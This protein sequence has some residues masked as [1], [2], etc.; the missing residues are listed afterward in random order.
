MT[1]PEINKPTGPEINKPAGDPQHKQEPPKPEP[2]PYVK[3]EIHPLAKGIFPPITGEEYKTLKEDIEAHGVR[4]AIVLYQGKILDGC[5]RD[6]VCYELNID[7]PTT[8]LPQDADPLEF[9]VSANI[10]RRHLDESQRGM[11]VAKLANMKRGDNQHTGQGQP[12]GATSRVLNVGE[13]TATRC[14]T[15]LTKGIP[16][17]TE[18]V[19]EGKLRASV[20]E[21]VANLDKGRQAEL[22]E[23]SVSKIKEAVKTPEALPQSTPQSTA[24]SNEV[25]KLKKAY[26][27]ALKKLGKAEQEAAVADMLKAFADLGL[28]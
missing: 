19:S 14:K 2:K 9:V 17:L 13:R 25:D 6:K 18:M 12:I 1:S 16:K 28:K 4:H 11:L 7:P 22:V 26:I 10:H 23:M 20:A 8:N 15:V 3:R 24:N 5:N 21:K 27:E